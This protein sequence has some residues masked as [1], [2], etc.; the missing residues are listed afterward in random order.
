LSQE[1]RSHLSLRQ[2]ARLLGFE[3]RFRNEIRNRMETA[4][5][6]GGMGGRRRPR[7]DRRRTPLRPRRQ[8]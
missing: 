5:H 8:P 4:R 3:D 1:I 6:G 2:Q 7:P